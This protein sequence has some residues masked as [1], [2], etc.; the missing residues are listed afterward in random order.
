MKKKL[1][2]ETLAKE[3]EDKFGFQPCKYLSEEGKCLHEG[4]DYYM[5]T[6]IKHVGYIYPLYER[7][8][9]WKKSYV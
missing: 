1:T 6:C 7:W 8:D 3:Y 2:L 9:E 5:Q 4:L